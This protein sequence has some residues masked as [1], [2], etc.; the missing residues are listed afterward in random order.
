MKRTQLFVLVSLALAGCP[1]TPAST[2][3]AGPG[4]DGGGGDRDTGSGDVDSGGGSD[5][6][7]VGPDGGTVLSGD[8]YSVTF[9]PVSVAPGEENTQCLIVRLGNPAGFHVGQIVNTLSTASHHF[10]VYRTNETVER[11]TPFDCQPF[12]D[13]LNPDAGSPLMITQRTD[14]TLTLP[15]G[16][17]FTLEADQMIRLELHFINPTG[18]PID[19]LAT[20]TMYGIPDS[21]FTDEADFLF[22]GTPDIDLP[23]HVSTRVGPY[24]FP[25]PAMYADTHFFAITG[26]THQYGTNVQVWTGPNQAE[27]TN[28][29]YDTAPFDWA[30]PQTVRPDPPFAIPPGGGFRFQCDYENTSDTNVGFGESANDEMCFFWAYYYPSHGAHVCAHTEQFGSINLCCPE[31]GLCSMLFR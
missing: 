13:T 21:A 25:I 17:A 8:S 11:T 12:V 28:P 31:S 15:P 2:V 1:A 9:G 30:E 14:E 16:V 29:V 3:D 23:P 26:H 6:G 22:I 5:S 10:I 27:A 24:Y 20:S 7:P 18:A 4:S 19:A